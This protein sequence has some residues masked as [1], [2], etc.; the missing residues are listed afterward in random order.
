[1]RTCSN[2]ALT[3]CAFAPWPCAVCR[4]WL[5]ERHACSGVEPLQG[6]LF[7]QKTNVISRVGIDWEYATVECAA[8]NGSAL[9][10]FGISKSEF[11]SRNA[12]FSVVNSKFRIWVRTEVPETSTARSAAR[13][14]S[15][16]SCVVFNGTDR[17]SR[18]LTDVVRCKRVPSV[19]G[20]RWRL[21]DR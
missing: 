13:L 8:G 10:E 18:V 19:G 5:H 14:M 7:V 15:L 21:V 20:V 1:M 12:D 9:T 2:M 6:S 17:L 11:R 4:C 16:Q 3:A